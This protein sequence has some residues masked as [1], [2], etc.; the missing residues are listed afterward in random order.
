MPDHALTMISSMA[1]P[2]TPARHQTL[3]QFLKVVTQVPFSRDLAIRTVEAN[4]ELLMQCLAFAHGQ[5]Q[6]SIAAWHKNLSDEVFKDLALTAAN[7]ELAR[8]AEQPHQSWHRA[9]LAQLLIERLGPEAGFARDELYRMKLLAILLSL[10]HQLLGVTEQPLPKTELLAL[11][12]RECQVCGDEA[13]AAWLAE[14]GYSRTDCDVLLYQYEDIEALHGASRDIVIMALVGQIADALLVDMTLPGLVIDALAKHFAVN[15]DTTK[16][17]VEAAYIELRAEND[18]L[19]GDVSF[20]ERLAQVNLA[21]QLESASTPTSLLDQGAECFAIT[22]L[23]FA[24]LQDDDLY[25]DCGGD[26]FQLSTQQ[27]KSVISNAFVTGSIVTAEGDALAAIIDKQILSRMAAN[28]LWLLPNENGVAVCGLRNVEVADA[29]EPYLLAAFQSACA[30]V[31]AADLDQSQNLIDLDE[32]QRRIREL[33]HEVNNPLAIVQNYLKTLSLR[34]GQNNEA[35]GDIKTISNEMLRIGTII[36]RYTEIGV[37]PAVSPAIDINDLINKLSSI[38]AGANPDIKLKLELDE[39][40]EQIHVPE[41]EL[42]Q[43]LLNLMKNAVEALSDT[44]KPKLNLSSGQVNVNGT[45]FIEVI[46]ADNGP[47][48]APEVYANLFAPNNTSKGAGHSG[49]GLSVVNRLVMEM[50]GYISCRSGK[51]GSQF[52]ILL[53]TSSTIST[54]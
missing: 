51:S 24:R 25:V 19:C 21:Q 52:Q 50:G 1:G 12:L 6:E 10:G 4:D 7:R 23:V 33:N 49:I 18:E 5:N 34:L 48:I 44:A 27:G 30:R 32:V 40:L 9:R 29:A 46:V 13:G 45:H 26:R 31:M 14:R 41:A 11:E 39:K 20:R 3:S 16:R 17:K 37:A 2:K 47:G 42:S 35:Q 38:V 54:Q 43:V 53:P 22:D 36:Q 15:P 8:G 28:V